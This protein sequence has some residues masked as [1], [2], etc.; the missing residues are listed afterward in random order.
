MGLAMP[1]VNLIKPRRIVDD[2]G[3][4]SETYSRKVAFDIGIT[5]D[6][7]QDNH[8]LSRRAGTLRGLHFQ[9]PPYA[10]AKL[11][12]CTRGKLMD[13]AV[14]LRRDSPTY[15]QH[16]AAELSAENG[17][18]LFVPIGFAH[19][20]ITLEPDTEV[21]YK[22]TNYYSPE[23]DGGIRFDDPNIAINW[24]AQSN[25]L[26]LS[27]KDLRLPTLADFDSPFVYD[28]TPLAPLK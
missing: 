4:F 16:V 21:V 13:Y 27:D 23:H 20:F 17:W 28:G 8:S 12:R 18:Q 1:G 22:V 7:V 9:T 14:D 15:G 26:I 11:I 25:D 6:F 2:R 24:V 19:G 3:W 10:Q 5:D